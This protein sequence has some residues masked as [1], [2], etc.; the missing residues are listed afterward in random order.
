MVEGG[1]NQTRFVDGSMC[2]SLSINMLQHIL[3]FMVEH[4]P[5]LQ[6]DQT[7]LRNA[8]S[9]LSDATGAAVVAASLSHLAL[10]TMSSLSPSNIDA[11]AFIVSF[12]ALS[13]MLAY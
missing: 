4:H 7:R 10:L 1:I 5:N 6:R 8:L 11:V 12:V 13:A 9:S 2:V 3:R